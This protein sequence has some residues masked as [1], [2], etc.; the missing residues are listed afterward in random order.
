MLALSPPIPRRRR[1]AFA[2][3]L[4]FAT[5]LGIGLTGSVHAPARSGI[6]CSL[7]LAR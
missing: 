1:L 5:L 7:H 6:S 2:L 3:A 4:A